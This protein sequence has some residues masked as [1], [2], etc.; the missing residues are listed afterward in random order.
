MIRP[1]LGYSHFGAVSKAVETAY[2]VPTLPNFMFS[3]FC[4][5]SSVFLTSF[6]SE[7]QARVSD[8]PVASAS[9]IFCI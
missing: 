4:L 9:S 3:L 8:S 2:C 6:M 1:I 7:G 5:L